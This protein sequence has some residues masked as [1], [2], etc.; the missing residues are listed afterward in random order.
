MIMF[1]DVVC[2]Y[3]LKF[4]VYGICVVLIGMVKLGR[5]CVLISWCVL[6]MWWIY[7]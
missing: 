1:V 6:L 2:Y 7:F 4:E 5:C 3:V